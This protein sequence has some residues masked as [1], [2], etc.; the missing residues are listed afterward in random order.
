MPMDSLKK[1]IYDGKR[2]DSRQAL[3]LFDWDLAELGLAADFRRRMAS[4]DERV[5][6]IVDRIINYTNVCEAKCDFCAYHA[7]AGRIA[8]YEM[9]LDEILAKVGELAEAGGTQVMLQ[10]GMHPDHRL[11]DYLEMVAAVKRHYPDIYLHSF[12]PSEVLHAARNSGISL[13][14]TVTRLK[15]AGVASV[16]GSSDILVDSVRQRVCPKKI[17][18]DEWIEVIRT[19][20]RH[21]MRSS[22]T[23]TYGLGETLSDRIAHFD[24]IRSVQDE[25]GILMAFIPWSF[26]PAN[27]RLTHIIPA[28]GVDYLKVVAIGRI[29]IDNITYIQAGWLTEGLKLAQIAL[30]M[31]ANDMG[32]VLTEEVVVKATGVETSTSM[33]EMIEL[34]RNAGK[35]PVQRDSRYSEIRSFA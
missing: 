18:K 14:E 16:P 11:E 35:I 5:G 13:D 32:G 9:P 29:Y 31:G 12:S 4:N 19:L 25:T 21:D 23:M 24:V 7:K 33:Q 34:I 15:A 1:T 10:G 30:A 22:A 27:T 8:P 28:T 6:F 17:T 2:I 3:E 20:A 26:S